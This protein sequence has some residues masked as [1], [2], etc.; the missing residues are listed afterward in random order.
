MPDYSCESLQGPGVEQAWNYI[1]QTCVTNCD[2]ECGYLSSCSLNK[3]IIINN[4]LNKQIII[5]SSKS[6]FLLNMDLMDF[7]TFGQ[8]SW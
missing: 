7:V 3:Q 5:I 4:S 8:N 2:L 1:L 6:L